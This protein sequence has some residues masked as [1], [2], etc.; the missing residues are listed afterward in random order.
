MTAGNASAATTTSLPDHIVNGDFEY[1]TSMPSQQDE[2]GKFWYI[3]LQDNS[4]WA[5]KPAYATEKRPALPS[6][7]DASKFAWESTQTGDTDW[8][9][10]ERVGD[11]Q[12]DTKGDGTNHYSE[13]TAAQA[14]STIYQDVAT[15]PGATYTWS[16]KHA[17]LSSAYVDKMSVMIGEPGKETAQQAYRE[18]VNGNGDTVGSVG[19]TIATK[20][21]NTDTDL[22]SGDIHAGQ[23]ETYTGKYVATGTVTRFAFHSIE[24]GGKTTGEAYDGNLIDDISFTVG[25]PLHYD[26]K[27]G[28]GTAPQQHD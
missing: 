27:G 3:S 15:V 1:P 4:W 24:G 26:L 5:C 2:N 14:G 25:Y 12:I 9:N 19:T 22:L 21:S 17:S 23:W 11:V 10:L 16:L 20:V 7:F 28:S 13:I 18:T 8:T 6:G